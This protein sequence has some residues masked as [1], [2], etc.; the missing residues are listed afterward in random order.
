MPPS[1]LKPSELAVEAK[2]TYIP[3]IERMLPQYPARSFVYVDSSLIQVA[4]SLRRERRLRIAV[5]DGDP[6]EVALDWY[7]A[8]V[9]S[10]RN[11][12]QGGGPVA[13]LSRIPVVNMANE[14]RAGGDWE[15]GV[16]A[17]EECF[18]RRSNLVHALNTVVEP[19]LVPHYPLAQKSG[20][21]SPFVGECR[22]P[23]LKSMLE[24]LM[25]LG[26][27][28]SIGP[29]RSPT[30]YGANSNLCPSSPSRPCVGPSWT[31]REPS[32]RLSRRR[33]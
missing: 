30:K 1:R 12:L 16:M 33:N 7:E 27:Q 18:C 15:A 22:C 25:S 2:R 13:E 21:F 26:E 32:M 4:P 17:F 23:S 29:G 5:I 9:K 28:S 3:Y 8:N 6:I 20:L 31:R 10:A 19:A 14:K 11:S 24:W